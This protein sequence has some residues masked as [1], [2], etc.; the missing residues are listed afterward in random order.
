MTYTTYDEPPNQ[1]DDM[2]ARKPGIVPYRPDASSGF[3]AYRDRRYQQIFEEHTDFGL[4]QAFPRNDRH[5]T[6][7]QTFDED[8]GSFGAETDP[9]EYTILLIH[10][11]RR[12]VRASF[13]SNR[14]IFFIIVTVGLVILAYPVLVE[15]LRLFI[16]AL[17]GTQ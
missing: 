3:G 8:F 9:Y 14:T 7:D 10:L 5:R 6:F 17:Q 16:R 11:D 2:R 13:Q 1:P 12:G 15:G 4:G